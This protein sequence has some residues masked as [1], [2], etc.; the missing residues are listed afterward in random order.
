MPIIQRNGALLV[1][2]TPPIGGEYTS[3]TPSPSAKDGCRDWKEQK[4]FLKEKQG[5]SRSE[6][7]SKF[8]PTW[9]KTI[10]QA[11]RFRVSTEKIRDVLMVAP[12]TRL[13]KH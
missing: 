12:G 3:I 9:R 13:K 7:L 8:Q 2:Q 1:V 10:S 5:T 4:K 11:N 6:M